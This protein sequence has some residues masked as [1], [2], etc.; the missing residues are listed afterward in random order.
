MYLTM[1]ILDYA[2]GRI[3]GRIGAQLQTD[4]DERVFN[5]AMTAR[6]TGRAPAE[7]AT[8]KRDLQG[9]QRAITRCDGVV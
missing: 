3:M 7:A 9:V 6:A 8:G 4:L 5:A 2:R 1:G